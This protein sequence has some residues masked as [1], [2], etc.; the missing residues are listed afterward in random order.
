MSDINKMFHKAMME[1]VKIKARLKE[2][3]DQLNQKDG[4]IEI[5][6]EAVDVYSHMDLTVSTGFE[7]IDINEYAIAALEKVKEIEVSGE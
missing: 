1:N 6:S 7:L 5:L 2:A 3:E 4:I